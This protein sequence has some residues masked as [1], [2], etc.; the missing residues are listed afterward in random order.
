MIM[1]NNN[2]EIKEGY[3]VE[4]QDADMYYGCTIRLIS[5][6][7]IKKVKYQKEVEIH[8]HCGDEMVTYNDVETHMEIFPYDTEKA[9]KQSAKQH[10][11]YNLKKIKEIRKFLDGVEK[12]CLKQTKKTRKVRK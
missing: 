9:A 10:M 11:T 7:T 8:P 1:T 5:G 6:Y 3:A 4:Y 2:N 12:A